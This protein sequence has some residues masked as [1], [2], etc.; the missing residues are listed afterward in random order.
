MQRQV[1]ITKAIFARGFCC[2]W[3]RVKGWTHIVDRQANHITCNA[4]RLSLFPVQCNTT[5]SVR[6]YMVIFGFPCRKMAKVLSRKGHIDLTKKTKTNM[7]AATVGTSLTPPRLI[8]VYLVF[9]LTEIWEKQKLGMQEFL[10]LKIRKILPW[11]Q[12]IAKR[13]L[14]VNWKTMKWLMIVHLIVCQ[15]KYILFNFLFPL[16]LLLFFFFFRQH[17]FWQAQELMH[18]PEKT[19]KC[20]LFISL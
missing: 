14:K 18:D 8:I 1:V 5:F 11:P 15:R 3:G 17:T 4:L 16:I 19:W 7:F 2:R 9:C 6:L 12:R 10:F 20:P 13:W